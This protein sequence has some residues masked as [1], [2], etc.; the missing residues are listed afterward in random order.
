M[1]TA[2]DYQNRYNRDQATKAWTARNTPH[3]GTFTGYPTSPTQWVGSPEFVAPAPYEYNPGAGEQTI[4]GITINT[5]IV[6]GRGGVLPGN[7]GLSPA[8]AA[9]YARNEALRRLRLKQLRDGT[10]MDLEFAKQSVDQARVKQADQY[11]R[12]LPTVAPSFLARGL[13]SSGITNTGIARYH[14]DYRTA[15]AELDSTYAQARA[16]LL[17]QIADA[18]AEAGLGSSMD[19]LSAG[20]QNWQSILDMVAKYS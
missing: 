5:P 7:A 11:N 2:Q 12:T 20:D 14:Q 19:A 15:A 16:K 9:E 6:Q 1:P 18:E 8:I 4:G 13:S 10:N 3:P 17:K